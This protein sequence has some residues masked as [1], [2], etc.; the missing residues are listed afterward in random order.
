MVI[1]MFLYAYNNFIVLVF[2]FCEYSFF[3][4]HKVIW[5]QEFLSNTKILPKLLWVHVL[6]Q[7]MYKYVNR[8]KIWAIFFVFDK[9]E[10]NS[11]NLFLSSQN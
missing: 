3:F 5:D 1:I 10:I 9:W 8:E 2:F 6:I 11:E 7:H 4:L